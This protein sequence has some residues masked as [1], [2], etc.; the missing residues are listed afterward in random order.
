MGATRADGLSWY[1]GGSLGPCDQW[2][3]SC[4]DDCRSTVGAELDVDTLK[5]LWRAAL[6]LPEPSGHHVWLHGELKPTNLLVRDGKLHAVIDV[7]GPC[8]GCR[9]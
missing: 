4:L 1:R 8:P 7:G 9:T 5:R 3:S 6:A 2:I